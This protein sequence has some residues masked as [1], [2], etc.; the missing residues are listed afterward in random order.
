[1]DDDSVGHMAS[2]S[3]N[4]PFVVVFVFAVVDRV[5]VMPLLLP[6]ETLRSTSF[7]GQG[8]AVNAAI[9]ANRERCSAVRGA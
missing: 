8:P 3:V 9:R 1:M 2:A 7:K 5:G 6:P 4:I